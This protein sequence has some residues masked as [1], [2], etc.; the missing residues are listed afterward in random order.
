MELL[1]SLVMRKTA[2]PRMSTYSL[3]VAPVAT[4]KMNGTRRVTTWPELFV[5][6]ARTVIRYSPGLRLPP[7]MVTVVD[8]LPLLDRLSV[9]GLTLI[10]PIPA[11]R[12]PL[13][14]GLPSTDRL[15][16]PLNVVD[17]L[18]VLNVIVPLPVEPVVA[19][20]M[21]SPA[22]ELEKSRATP[23]MLIPTG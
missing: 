20:G 12:T 2:Q 19:T 14:W 5:P 11:G 17:A 18:P 13:S 10:A 9:D 4:S 1:M 21:T 6:V 3:D 15:I 22:L 7:L 8:R 23:P 16:V